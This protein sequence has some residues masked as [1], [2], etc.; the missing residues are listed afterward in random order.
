MFSEVTHVRGPGPHPEGGRRPG[1]VTPAVGAGVG[2]GAGAGHRAETDTG[3]AA[4]QGAGQHL[5]SVDHLHNLVPLL[6]NRQR[7]LKTCFLFSFVKMC[8]ARVEI[9]SANQRPR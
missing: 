9:L 8:S 3:H 2:T 5:R 6:E 7:T 4:G 1:G